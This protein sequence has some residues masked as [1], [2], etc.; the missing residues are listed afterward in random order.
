MAQGSILHKVM[1]KNA[2]KNDW[3]TYILMTLDFLSSSL[4]V[5]HV[6]SLMFFGNGTWDEKD[7][8]TSNSRYDRHTTFENAID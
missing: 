3:T 1:P 4:K 2:S 5:L 8:G 7:G 6:K